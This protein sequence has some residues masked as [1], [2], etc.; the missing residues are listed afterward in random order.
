MEILLRYL[1]H[2]IQDTLALG[3]DYEQHNVHQ[4]ID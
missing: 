4:G 3:V 1:L 2:K